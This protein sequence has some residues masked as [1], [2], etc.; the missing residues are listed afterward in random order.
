MNLEQGPPQQE[1][2]RELGGGIEGAPSRRLLQTTAPTDAPTADPTHAPSVAP[3]DTKAPTMDPTHAPTPTTAPSVAPTIQPTLDPTA[4]TASPTISPTQSPTADPTNSP[5]A[6]P[7]Q[8]PTRRQTRSPTLGPTLG[9]TPDPTFSVDPDLRGPACAI[10]PAAY[11]LYL[12]PDPVFTESTVEKS[13]TH[14]KNVLRRSFS[15]PWSGFD[16][17]QST[18]T[19]FTASPTPAPACTTETCGTTDVH[20]SRIPAPI[21]LGYGLPMILCMIMAYF[22]WF[23]KVSH[24]MPRLALCIIALLTGLTIMNLSLIHISEPTRLLSISYAVF[25]LKKKKKKTI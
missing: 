17:H 18:T 12:A 8:S 16:L 19:L 2:P 25:C 3:T 20:M 5:T 21:V 9:P 15:T 6:G 11:N 22:T 13:S 10:H 24:M 23:L 7:T 4:H 14:T 1:P